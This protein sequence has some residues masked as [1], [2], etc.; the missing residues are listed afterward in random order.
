MDAQRPDVRHKICPMCNGAGILTRTPHDTVKMSKQEFDDLIH[1]ALP[2]PVPP[3]EDD[4][5]EPLIFHPS[6]P[7]PQ[8]LAETL[9]NE[10]WMQ[11]RID[12]IRLENT[13]F[14]WVLL[15]VVVAIVTA[16]LVV[17]QWH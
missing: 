4:P 9:A 2:T 6:P 8:D 12:R 7:L 16:I 3:N 11:K 13:Y 17:T 10:T 15:F 1:D 5:F 14:L